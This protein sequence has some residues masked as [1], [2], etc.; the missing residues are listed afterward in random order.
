MVGDPPRRAV[1]NHDERA[2]TIKAIATQ[3]AFVSA[4]SLM[5]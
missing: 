4:P 2:I 3:I 1:S 5:E